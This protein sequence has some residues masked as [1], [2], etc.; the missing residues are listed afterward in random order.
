MSTYEVGYGKPPKRSRFKPGV[1][2]NPRGR[3]K[4]ESSPLARIIQ[5]ALEASI[6]Y[7]DKGIKKAA[8]RYEITLKM[9]VA[10]AVKGDV[11]AAELVLKVRAQAKKYGDAGIDRLQISDWLPDY[12]GQTASQKTKDITGGPAAEPTQ[13]WKKSQSDE[14]AKSEAD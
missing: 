10:S 6:E 3:P 14:S 1:S 9:V 12:P 4:R 13:W 5:N 7:R 2:G 11:S 8:T